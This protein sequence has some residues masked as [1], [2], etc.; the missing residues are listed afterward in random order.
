MISLIKSIDTTLPCSLNS[1]RPLINASDIIYVESIDRQTRV[2]TDKN[3]YDT[4]LKLY[5]IL[6]ILKSS[7]FVQISKYCILNI[8]FL[9][10]IKTLF[11]SRMEAALTNGEHLTVTRKF[12]PAIKAKL[13]ER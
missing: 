7:G 12:I 9:N 1:E 8:E 11:N 3:I 6:D 13:L 5:Q 2:H 4:G 10:S